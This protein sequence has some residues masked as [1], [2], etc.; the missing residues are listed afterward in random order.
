MLKTSLL[1]VFL[2]IAAAYVHWLNQSASLTVA[3]PMLHFDHNQNKSLRL[4]AFGD[5]GMGNENQEKVMRL[6]E[7][8]CQDRK[9][10]GIL[11]LGDNIYMDGVQSI[12]DPKWKSVIEDPFNKPCLSKLPLFPILGN[13][14]YKGNAD[15]QIEYSK[16]KENWHFPSRF[17]SVKFGS[18]LEIVALDSNFAD[19]CLDKDNCVLDFAYERLNNKNTR[20]QIAMGHHPLMASS[21]KHSPGVQGLLLTPMF[22]RFDAYLAGHSHH[23]EHVKPNSCNGEFF[24]SGAG[25]ADIY[26]VKEQI[27]ESKFAKSTYGILELEVDRSSITYKFIDTEM[28]ELYRLD[29]KPIATRKTP[30]N[31]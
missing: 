30:T 23:L 1:G 16:I 28:N 15:A 20:W 6:V 18:L 31:L 19:V 21:S 27:S 5:Y 7:N 3:K 9:V 26:P 24:I 25:G 13:H 12:H 11:L 22:C 8:I 4:L 17:Y 10:D 14:D 2:L 29:S